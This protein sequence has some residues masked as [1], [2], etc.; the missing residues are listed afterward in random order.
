MNTKLAGPSGMT[1]TER[2]DELADL[3]KA[4]IARRFRAKELLKSIRLIDKGR[5]ISSVVSA[6]IDVYF[7]DEDHG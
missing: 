5:P 6:A 2:E 3:L 4:E 1:V 7:E